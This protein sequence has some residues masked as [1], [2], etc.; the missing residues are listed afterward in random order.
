MI[1]C[2][3]FFAN[4]VALAYCVFVG[5]YSGNP[6]NVF[7]ATDKNGNICGQSGT[8][9]ADYPYS[10]LY[11][12]TNYISNRVCV[13]T[14]PYF[15]SGS[16]TTLDCYNMT[17]TYQMVVYSNGSFNVTPNSVSDVVGYETETTLD[18]VCL[19]SSVVLS[20]AFSAVSSSISSTVSQGVIGS[21]VTDIQNNYVYI[22]IGVAMAVVMSFIIIFLLRCFVGVIV[23]ACIFGIILLLSAIGIIFLYNGGAL[24]AYSSYIGS[25]GIPT[26]ESS[27]Y[28]NYYGYAV[29]GVVGV[30]LILL[31]CCCGRI[32][33]AVAICKAAG[34]FITSVPQTMLVP[35]FMSIIII[36]FWAFALVI[37]VYLMGSAT[38]TSTEGDVFSS[39]SNYQEDKLIYLYYFVFGSLWINALLGAITIFVVASACCMWYYSHGPGAEL[40][41]PIMKSFYMAFRYHFGSLAFG[42]LILAIVQFMQIVV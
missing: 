26:L 12:P 20:N 2:L 15:S 13:K 34:G 24:S 16:L 41:S 22:L 40:D 28:Y 32:R 42:S 25:L 8:N 33:L 14:C 10:Y 6:D 23:W 1:C 36:A 18:R 5:F 19:P 27:D 9:T 38:Y 3:L 4:L 21:T 31:L 11:N 37:I 39:I 29:F 30:L 17:C 7:R 35:I